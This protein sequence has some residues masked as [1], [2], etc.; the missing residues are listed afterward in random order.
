MGLKLISARQRHEAVA[1]LKDQNTVDGQ[2]AC[3]HWGRVRVSV[4]I[5]GE[6]PPQYFYAGRVLSAFTGVWI[7]E[8]EQQGKPNDARPGSRWIL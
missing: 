6:D 3:F 4:D 8:V 5:G 7:W 1:N 2:G